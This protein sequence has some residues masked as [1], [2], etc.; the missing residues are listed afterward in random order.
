MSSTDDG[1]PYYIR[2]GADKDGRVFYDCSCHKME[3]ADS[4][5]EAR[6]KLEEHVW[7]AHGKRLGEL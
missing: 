3:W 1:H 5:E 2:G 7:E 4:H 6:R